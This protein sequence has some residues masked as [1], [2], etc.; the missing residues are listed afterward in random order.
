[1][2]ITLILPRKIGADDIEMGLGSFTYTDPVTGLPTSNQRLNAGL[3]P[4]TNGTV[5]SNLTQILADMGS[6][7]LLSSLSVTVDTTVPAT[8]ALRA[9]PD[10][11]ITIPN[12]VTLTINGP[13]QAG[14]YQCF[15]CVGTGKVLFAQ[16]S[17]P[18]VRPEW[19]YSG[20]GSWHTALNA[21]YKAFDGDTELDTGVTIGYVSV[22]LSTMYEVIDNPWLMDDLR[23]G[24]IIGAG[25]G[26]AGVY[27]S[28]TGDAIS[29]QTGANNPHLSLWRFTV[30]GNA[31]SDCGIV[32]NGTNLSFHDIELLN[33]GTHGF[34][35]TANGWGC[36]F[37]NVLS[38][39]NGV[40]G[41]RFSDVGDDISFRRGGA[42]YNG[43]WGMNMDISS[44]T[45]GTLFQTT[46]WGYNGAGGI[47]VGGGQVNVF[48]SYFES[49]TG[50]QLYHYAFAGTGTICGNSFYDA[51]GVVTQ[52]IRLD[53][54]VAPNNGKGMV[55]QANMFQGC[56]TNIWQ[57]GACEA[58]VIGPNYAIDGVDAISGTSNTY[59]LGTSEN[60]YIDSAAT[61]YPSTDGTAAGTKVKEFTV[62]TLA[63]DAVFTAP[64]GT[65]S[66]WDKLTIRIKD[67]GTPR[68]LDFTTAACYRPVGVTLPTTTSANKWVYLSMVYDID[69]PEWHVIE[70]IEEI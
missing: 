11:P 9:N 28:G 65:W 64:V 36:T 69:I 17:V 34:H 57:S 52:A 29:I 20:S 62:T 8:T 66:N 44:I 55:V 3:I 31:T 33:N 41:F 60:G 16:G 53:S 37:T 2:S 22:Y 56:T 68:T 18:F 25:R 40:D 54:P 51:S 1:M 49:N 26:K 38:H 24:S 15:N 46:A 19:W 12:G 67:D 4:A 27:Q 35:S 21:A 45:K 5:Q 14:N 50:I 39:Y 7:V 23:A 59:I 43:G 61:I 63:H 10:E 42:S 58:Y 47:F 48:S 30:T 6:W 13:F 32:T 70:V